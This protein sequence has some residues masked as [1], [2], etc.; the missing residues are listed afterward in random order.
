[1]AF[2]G[3]I[4]YHHY[5][6]SIEAQAGEFFPQLL[7]QAN[8]NIDKQ[9]MELQKLNE[10]L[11]SSSSVMSILRNEEYPNQST[12]LRDKFEMNTYLSNAYLSGIHYDIIA[13][14]IQSNNRLFHHSRVDIVS[15]AQLEHVPSYGQHQ[16]TPFFETDLRFEGDIPFL[17]IEREIIDFDNQKSLGTM[18]I[19]LDLQFIDQ[20]VEEMRDGGDIWLMDQD[21]RI[22]YHSDQSRIGERFNDVEQLPVQHGSF[23]TLTNDDN[24]VISVSTSDEHQWILT[25]S[26]PAKHLT[27]RT[28]FVRN[29][30]IIIFIAFVVVFVIISILL[31]W[32]VSRPIHRLS[33]LM[34]A[35]ERGDFD[36]DIPKHPKSQDEVA[37]LT[38]SFHSMVTRI[39]ELIRSNYQTALRQKE[40]ELYALQ[41]QIN[42]HFMYNTLETISMMVEEDDKETVVEVVSIL[43]KMLR[44]S[45]SNKDEAVLIATEV[46]HIRDFL[47]IQ[48][49]RFEDRLSFSIEQNIDGQ[50]YF[51]PKFILQPIV[52]NAVKYTIE[53]KEEAMVHVSVEK[54]DDEIVCLVRDNG[55]GI[56]PEK[57]IELEKQL[58]AELMLKKDSSFGLKNVHARIVMMYGESYGLR[59]HSE[60]GGGT[61][62]IIR[63]PIMRYLGEGGSVE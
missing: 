49:Y 43:G 57:L 59:I 44:Y 24:K 4:S 30:T 19:A 20:V 56:A 14:F 2:L 63:L 6:K 48:K 8:M 15:E 32:N 41:F 38:R 25:H 3:F 54:V 61:E 13:V 12:L 40:A 23:K 51:T 37:V 33:L 31:A 9:I 42:P 29:M 28:D 52:E 60:V 7:K 27:D 22:L 36:I 5:T 45:L 17:L 62:I 10:L 34:G 50:Q 16:V 18:F 53:D 58:K 47:T 1:M 11:Y 21:Y 26:I 35:V 55:P 46:D 39:K